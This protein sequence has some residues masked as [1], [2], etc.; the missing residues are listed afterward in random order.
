LININHPYRYY[1]SPLE[2][3]IMLL[4]NP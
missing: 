3:S 4:N 1:F 2:N